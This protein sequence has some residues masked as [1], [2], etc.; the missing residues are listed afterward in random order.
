MLGWHLS[1]QEGLRGF[2]S[3][4]LHQIYARRFHWRGSLRYKQVVQSS[5]LWAS[6]NFRRE[7]HLDEHCPDKAKAAGSNLAPPTNL[8]KETS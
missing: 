2:D 7:A 3:R 1:L 5:T 8:Q 4:I 6:T